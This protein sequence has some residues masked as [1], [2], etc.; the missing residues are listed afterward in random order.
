MRPSPLLV[1]P[2]CAG[3]LFPTALPAVAAEPVP[4]SVVHQC[5]TS[6]AEPLERSSA[7]TAICRVEIDGSDPRVL[8]N[9]EGVFLDEPKWS[10]D[11]RRVA[12]TSRREGV[13]VMAAD[14]SAREV[15]AD[16]EFRFVA[17]APDGTRLAFTGNGEDQG[18]WVLDLV[19]DDLRRLHEG[20]DTHPSWA[21]DG[22][23][24]AI[25]VAIPVPERDYSSDHLV[26]VPLDGG[27][28]RDLGEAGGPAPWSPDGRFV[29]VAD[30]ALR[31]LA[32]DGSGSRNLKV[33]P[34]GAT[35][36]EQGLTIY[37]D[38][39]WS[40]DGSRLAFASY[41]LAPEPQPD[42]SGLGTIGADGSDE[43][44]VTREPGTATDTSDRSAQWRPDGSELVFVRGTQDPDTDLKDVRTDLYAVRP[45]GSGLRRLTDGAEATEPDLPPL[46]TRPA[47][48]TRV[49]TAVS[50]SR[51]TRGTAD[52]VVLAR[53]DAFP[54]ALS[55][56]PLAASQDAPLLL[57][58]PDR[59]PQAVLDE[60]RRLGARTA[61]L[62]GDTSALS[63]GVEAD[64]RAAGVVDVR[65]LG[66]ATRYDTAAE[67]AREIG[68]REVYVA[69]GEVFADA[70]SVSALAAHQ[71]RPILL[72][73]QDRVPAA[74]ARALDDLRVSAVTV[75]GGLVAVSQEAADELGRGRT[76]DRLSGSDRY[77]T[78]AAVAERSV[79]AG[80]GTGAPW[81]ATGRDF[82][83]ALAAGP[84][85]AATGGV[86]LLVDPV[87]LERSPASAQ[88][89]ADRRRDVPD[90]VA[91][92]GPDVVGPAVLTAAVRSAP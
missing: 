63:A 20:S 47:G 50:V 89:L 56:A 80:L 58:P 65:R 16:G 10:P 69:W 40:P 4:T 74:T 92:G 60:V 53:S 79:A 5:L 35:G 51:A 27:T 54:D 67:V 22:S 24:L 26:V 70:A 42:S 77:G 75:V 41:T 3:F 37:S 84:G 6:P 55:A 43:R 76:L 12:Y 83:D 33:N 29:A 71:R 28:P 64:L 1:V 7:P 8:A 11:G 23:A 61:Y 44:V 13:V 72:T 46:V 45:D 48:R 62:V 19:G 31:L 68:G 90:V 36:N 30:H 2:L 78:S 9:D 15:V 38:V 82:P 32:V 39:A 21:P 87:A 73:A 86:L 81:L 59:A 25:T 66:G 88:W 91:V 57:S 49:D 52:T 18:L 34:G 17:W 85:A 14:G